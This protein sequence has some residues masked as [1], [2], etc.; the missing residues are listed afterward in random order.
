MW[1]SNASHRVFDSLASILAP[2]ALI[3]TAAAV[4]SCDRPGPAG[5]D[6]GRFDPA[7]KGKPGGTG[8][9]IVSS[10][11]PPEAEQGVTLDVAVLGENF[12]RG[13][14]S[15][16][17]DPAEGCTWA[18]FGIDEQVT[19][20]VKTNRTRYVNSRKLIANITIDPE[21]TVGLY[22]AIVTLRGSRGVGTERFRVKI[23]AN[24]I[25]VMPVEVTFDDRDGD[26]LRSDFLSSGTRSYAD[27]DDPTTNIQA[28]ISTCETCTSRGRVLL[29]RRM[30]YVRNKLVWSD[31][32]FLL[33]AEQSNPELADALDDPD[34]CGS[35]PCEAGFQIIISGGFNESTFMRL[36]DD[37]DV[38]LM[39][40][41]LELAENQSATTRAGMTLGFEPKRVI[42]YG[43]DC[44]TPISS[45]AADVEDN[46]VTVTRLPDEAGYRVWAVEGFTAHI[47]VFF[48]SGTG[49]PRADRD[50]AAE[51][52]LPYGFDV[53]F[54]FVIR[55]IGPLAPR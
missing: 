40:G 10:V 2:A 13:D 41:L 42:R 21:A 31:R 16:C 28:G 12:P 49:K 35:N 32:L 7:F 44:S 51:H 20:K 46:R 24:E 18:E 37:P 34:V 23:R 43:S 11:D 30:G 38:L 14:P 27:G 48:G 22:D 52:G 53:P 50:L 19:G 3:L 15:E 17:A 26:V 36:V 1:Y 29:E 55:Q 25:L 54:R 33:E 5:L 9:I 6:D 4:A 45:V 47:C 8:D 39:D